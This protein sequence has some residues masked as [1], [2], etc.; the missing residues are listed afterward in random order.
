MLQRWEHK[1][2][3][4]MEDLVSKLSKAREQVLKTCPGT[5]ASTKTLLQVLD[6]RKFVECEKDYAIFRMGFC[7]WLK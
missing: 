1:S 3:E 2:A 4:R 5:L 7:Y 6:H